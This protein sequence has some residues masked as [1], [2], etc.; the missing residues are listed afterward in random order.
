MV[1]V[2]RTVTVSAQPSVVVGYLADFTNAT[3]WDPGTDECVR[4]DDGPVAPGARW[5]NT[6]TVLGR[7]TELEYRLE[8][9][10]DDR[11]VLVGRNSTATARDVITVRADGAGSEITYDATVELHGVAKLAS[12]VM[13]LEFERLGNRTV[14]GLRKALG[15]GSAH[16]TP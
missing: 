8:E 4:I 16:P 2:V 3:E 9:L 12:P 15:D 7:Q 5:K 6:S 11:I 1:H 10:T 13:Q 14:E